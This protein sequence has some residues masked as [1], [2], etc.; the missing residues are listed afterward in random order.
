MEGR[1]MCREQEGAV[2]SKPRKD[3][4]SKG[5]KHLTPPSRGAGNTLK[6]S[7]CLWLPLHVCPLAE[8]GGTKD[9]SLSLPLR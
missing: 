2:P 5:S 9:I 1:K 6:G 4:R 8:L 3:L 7:V